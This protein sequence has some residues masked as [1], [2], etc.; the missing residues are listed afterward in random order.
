MSCRGV[1]RRACSPAMVKS[2]S[3]TLIPAVLLGVALLAQP[4]A[5]DQR[6]EAERLAKSGAYAQALKAFQAL[7]AANPDDLEARLWIARLHVSMGQPGRAADVYQSIVAAQPQNVDALIGLGTSLT[8][9]GRFRE[10]GD[11]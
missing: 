7:A 1:R 8:M 10:A 4:Q 9:A 11:A 3:M 2:P 6:A 5:P